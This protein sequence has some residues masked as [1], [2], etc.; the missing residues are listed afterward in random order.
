MTNVSTLLKIDSD[1]VAESLEEASVKL[2]DGA[3]NIVLDFSAVHRIDPGALRAMQQLACAA[4]EKSVKVSL[5]GV[6]VEIYKVLKLVSLAS[7]F[8]F[9]TEV[10]QVGTV[11]D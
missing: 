1:H 6:N 10:V 4:E 9:L 7:R 8:N 11:A 3:A 5:L 2:F